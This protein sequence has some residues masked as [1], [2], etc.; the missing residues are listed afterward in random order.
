MDKDF[1]IFIEKAE[2]ILAGC[3]SFATKNDKI[4][5]LNRKFRLNKKESEIFLKV[6][7]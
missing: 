3:P 4:A 6:L 1:K 7:K 2:K 5:M